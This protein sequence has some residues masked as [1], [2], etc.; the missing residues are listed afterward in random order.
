MAGH[1]AIKYFVPFEH[2]GSFHD[3]VQENSGGSNGILYYHSFLIQ[4]SSPLKHFPGRIV[5]KLKS[6]YI[7]KQKLQINFYDEFDT[8]S[9]ASK[10]KA[11]R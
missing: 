3:V 10:C 7:S 1:Q 5:I 8:Q 6:T 2:R 4:I 11:C 9:F